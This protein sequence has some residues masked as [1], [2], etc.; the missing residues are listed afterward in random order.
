MKS[1][2][3]LWEVVVGSSALFCKKERYELPFSRKVD[4]KSSWSNVESSEVTF[5]IGSMLH[6]PFGRNKTALSWVEGVLV[7]FIRVDSSESHLCRLR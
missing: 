6:A 4:L 7:P 3:L 1:I 2:W 5:V